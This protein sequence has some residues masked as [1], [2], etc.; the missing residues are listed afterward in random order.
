MLHF[1]AH[2]LPNS[3]VSDQKGDDLSRQL[4]QSL[5]SVE[6]TTSPTALSII[7]P[8]EHNRCS[9]VRLNTV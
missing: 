8:S 2:W 4:I 5:I 9:N 7:P 6:Y 3:L 1:A